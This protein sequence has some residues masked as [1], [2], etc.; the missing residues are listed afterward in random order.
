MDQGLHFECRFP[1]L[2]HETH[3]VQFLTMSFVLPK[4]TQKTVKQGKQ[5]DVNCGAFVCTQALLTSNIHRM[6]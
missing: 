1:W 3:Q 4:Q 2:S 6:D 5:Q